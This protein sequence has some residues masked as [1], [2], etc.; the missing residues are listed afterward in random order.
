MDGE[1]MERLV[2]ALAQRDN[3]PIGCYEPNRNRTNQTTKQAAKN[4]AAG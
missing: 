2:Q 3:S 1:D 4:E